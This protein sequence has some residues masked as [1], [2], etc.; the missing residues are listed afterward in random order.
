MENLILILILIITGVTS[1]MAFN[2]T[3]AFDKMKFNAYAILHHRQWHRFFTYGF[4]HANW[5]HLIFN[6]YVLWAFG[7]IVMLF[8]Q[9]HFG[10][11]ANLYF[12][13]LYFPAIALSSLW[14]F[15]RH[16]DDAY[17]NA[18]GASG[19]VS[20]VVFASIILYPQGQMGLI[21]IPIMLPSWIF[22]G[23]Y[24]VYTIVMSRKQIDNIGHDAH[25]WGAIYG[26]AYTLLTV[27]NAFKNFL[28][29]VLN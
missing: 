26:I 16:C 8:F 11:F 12:I 21:F 18:V 7:K 4:I 17:Y 22:G 10:N 27:P 29:H 13:G 20:A 28:Y 23:L 25:F 14:D 2:N 5:M 3:E 15:F 24:L 6:L 9:Y 19:A 1:Y